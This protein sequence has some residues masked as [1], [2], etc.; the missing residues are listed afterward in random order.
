MTVNTFSNVNILTQLFNGYLKKYFF[1]AS[2]SAI[3]LALFYVKKKKKGLINKN[4][5]R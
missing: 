4:G 3:A 5:A 1:I 2:S